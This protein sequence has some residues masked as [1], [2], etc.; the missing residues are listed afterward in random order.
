M[1]QL[2]E[3][4]LTIYTDGS[5]YS[6]PRVGGVGFIFIAVDDEGHEET[7]EECPPGWKGATNNQM[8]LQA[9]I[10][11]LRI[12]TGRPPPFD[13][14]RF[15]KIV[16]RSDSE[17]V[18]DNFTKVKFEWPGNRWR[19]RSG[20]PVLN[21]PEWQ[22]LLRLV[23]RIDRDSRL[24]VEIQWVKGHKKDRFNK[25]VDNLAKQSAKSPS[26]RTSGPQRVRRKKSPYAVEIGSVRMEGQVA[27]VHI[28]TDQY[29]RSPHKC[30]RYMYEVMDEGSRFFRR[31]DYV[32]ADVML[33]AGHTYS[34]RFND[35]SSNP[36]IEEML[37]EI[38]EE[39]P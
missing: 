10:E 13:L 9:C 11:A 15:D 8:E 17:Y 19:T 4:A 32:T 21:T 14:S 3:L 31:V 27:T 7:H 33:S 25:R 23:R 20:A 30:Y 6:S 5:S 18:C 12:A 22:E 39:G 16:I 34:V 29:L 35:N 28:I 2:D 36:R 1:Q 24:R 26:R 37:A 38:V